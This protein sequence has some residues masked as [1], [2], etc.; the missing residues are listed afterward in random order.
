[1][2]EVTIAQELLG[3]IMQV[4]RDHGADRVTSATV[5]IGELSS[6]QPRALDFAFEVVRAGTLAGECRLKVQTAPLVVRCARCE[7][8]GRA[9]REQLCCPGCG[10]A[11]VE[12][13]SGRELRL[14]AIDVED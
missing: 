4:A 6:V 1:M 11:P 2:H 3:L 13:V 8:E 14:V 12:V 7:Q 5:E 9:R 10:A